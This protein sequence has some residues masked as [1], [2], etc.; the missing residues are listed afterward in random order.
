MRLGILG[1]TFNPIHM[2]HLLLAEAAR[3]QCRLDQVWFIPTA[4]PPHKSAQHVAL[5]A[6]R[7]AF[8]RLA[9][10]GHP[11]FRACDMELRRGGVSYTVDTVRALRQHHPASQLFLVVGSDMLSVSW[12]A[13]DEI[14]QCCTVVVAERPTHASMRHVPGVNPVPPRQG[15]SGFS[16][17]PSGLP[18][19]GVKRLAMPHIEISSSMIRHRI[20]HGRSIRYLVPDAVARYIVRHRLYQ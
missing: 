10:R 14:T 19:D 17:S 7:L 8:I 1:G 15:R 18:R 6:H 16:K 5:G 4:T 12:V 9:I 3:E 2:G 11:A 20:R 13:F